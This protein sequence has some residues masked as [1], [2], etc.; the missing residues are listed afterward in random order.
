MRA[1]A[2]LVMCSSFSF[3]QDAREIVLRSLDRD[4]R[5]D[6]IARNYTFVERNDTRQLDGQGR[7][8]KRDVLSYD[9]TLLVGSPYRRLIARDDKPLPPAEEKREREKLQ[10]SIEQRQKETEAQRAKRVADWEKKRQEGRAFLMEIPDAFNLRVAGQERVDDV[11][12]WIIEATPRAGYR[13]KARMARILQKFKGRLWI[14]KRD[15]VWVKVEA[16]ALD[17]IS[18]GLIL[19]RLQK[20]ASLSVVQ[21][22]VNDEVWLPRTVEVSLSARVALVK[23]IR[24]A[25]EITFKDYRKFQAESR[26]LGFELQK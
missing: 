23:T 17:S 13:P 3:A 1:A 24:F 2:V 15:S 10:K 4:D 8:K 19:A 18:Y 21:T 11:D 6:R 22:H 9:V 25:A 14:D 5:N 7:V 26:L 16:E 20:G 12:A